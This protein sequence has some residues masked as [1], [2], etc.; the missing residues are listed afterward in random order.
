MRRR[1]L[2]LCDAHFGNAVVSSFLGVCP[3]QAELWVYHS[4]AVNH[5][6][7]SFDERIT[8]G[9]I[10]TV[11]RRHLLT[12]TAVCRSIMLRRKKYFRFDILKVTIWGPVGRAF[13]L[14]S[15]SGTEVDTDWNGWEFLK[16]QVQ[17][18]QV[19]RSFATK[20]R[21][22]RNLKLAITVAFAHSRRQRFGCRQC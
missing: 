6:W 14:Q 21:L 18:T 13:G 12:A 22:I 19:T 20:S 8:C 15:E 1:S 11:A 9:I 17:T 3:S 10:S 2:W 16:L 5:E 7:T 4:V